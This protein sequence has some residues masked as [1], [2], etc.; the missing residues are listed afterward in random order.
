LN[1]YRKN[2]DF[3]GNIITSEKTE[4]GRTTHWVKNLQLLF[5][6]NNHNC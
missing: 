6:I 1:V 4:D 5:N 2:Y 3:N